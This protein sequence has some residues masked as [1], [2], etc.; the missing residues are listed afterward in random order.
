MTT[1]IT[2]ALSHNVLPSISFS[3]VNTVVISLFLTPSPLTPSNSSFS[4]NSSFHHLHI[5]VILT[6]LLL[7]APSDFRSVKLL[8]PIYP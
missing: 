1:G 7:E 8:L 2:F 4:S 3:Q 5:L 6:D